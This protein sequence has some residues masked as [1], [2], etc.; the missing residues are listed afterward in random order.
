MY[1]TVQEIA[2]QKNQKEIPLLPDYDTVDNVI[3]KPTASSNNTAA[4]SKSSEAPSSAGNEVAAAV[5][6]YSVVTKK[7]KQPAKDKENSDYNVL[8]HNSVAV[9]SPAHPIPSAVQATYSSISRG[10]TGEGPNGTA[11]SQNRSSGLH[12][13]DNDVS[14]PLPPP[15]SAS[16]LPSPTFNQAAPNNSKVL[17]QNQESIDKS[18]EALY[19]N[20]NDAVLEMDASKNPSDPAVAASQSGERPVEDGGNTVALDDKLMEGIYMNV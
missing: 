11:G 1:D 14:P 18:A 7:T 3:N 9:V 20:V 10:G 17:K 19:G 8:M 4:H 6:E 15:I 13:P 2:P 5:V 16:D 12:D